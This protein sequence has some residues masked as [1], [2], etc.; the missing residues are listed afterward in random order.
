MNTEGQVEGSTN[1]MKQRVAFYY[2]AGNLKIDWIYKEGIKNIPSSQAGLVSGLN[3]YTRNPLADTHFL[4]SVNH[5]FN[6]HDEVCHS[7][8]YSCIVWYHLCLRQYHFPPDTFSLL[9][10]LCVEE[11]RVHKINL[12]V[13]LKCE[14][15]VTVN[16]YRAECS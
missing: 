14:L 12:D 15:H 16:A 10:Y 13:Y 9:Q 1:K 8:F 5:E 3:T 4:H 7:E 2:F 6:F 11:W